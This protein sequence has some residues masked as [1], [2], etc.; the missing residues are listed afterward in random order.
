VLPDRAVLPAEK[1]APARRAAAPISD[2]MVTGVTHDSRAVQPGDIYAA[3]PGSRVHGAEFAGQA[4]AAGAVAVL[5][6]P[7]GGPAVEA[8]GLPAVIVE[9]P[10]AAL[11]PVAAQIYGDPTAEL[12]VIGITGT[13]GKTTTAY[14]IEAGLRAAG[15]VTGLFGTVETRLADEVL[16]SLRTTPEAPE[17]QALLAVAVERGVTAVVMEVSSHALALSRVAGVRFD[18]GVFTNLGTD[19][20]DFHGDEESYFAAKARLFDGR[21]AHAVINIDDPAGRRLAAPGS[22]T[23]SPSGADADWRV[24]ERAASGYTQTF[25]L[26]GPDEV[27]LETGVG[28]PGDYNVDNAALAIAALAAVGVEPAAAASAVARGGAVPGRMERVPL[29][30]V[31]ADAPEVDADASEADVVEGDGDVLAIVDYAHDP[32]SVAAALAALRPVTEGR[33]I[34]VLGCGGDRDTGKR[35]L[36]GAA[37]ARGSDIFIAT[38][39]NPRTE[40][41]WL[42][43]A[44]MLE[45]VTRVPRAERGE[46]VEI[47]DRRTAILEA[48]RRS[49]PGDT[50]AV[51]GKGH[52]Q[53]QEVG[54]VVHPFDDRGVLAD[55][56]REVYG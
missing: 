13:N 55:A 34:C 53:G 18:V 45:G 36:M 31:P 23:V 14:L 21:C 39:D 15:H 49:E 19:H 6:D 40:E 1:P 54:T 29:P 10:R 42:I 27:E 30:P 4:A 44:S 12:T 37:A 7:A 50:I 17:L 8:A 41:P 52:E 56:L 11:G 35:P 32:R 38:D 33:L 28:M 48:V 5:T 43:R 9:D 3:L 51:L 16:P 47:G 26:A 25:R 46:V 20:L 2:V 24:T 22:I